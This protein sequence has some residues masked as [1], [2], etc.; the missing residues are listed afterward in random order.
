MPHAPMAIGCVGSTSYDSRTDR[1]LNK[2]EVTAPP[3]EGAYIHGL[4]MEVHEIALHQE[5]FLTQGARW[6]LYAGSIAESKLKDLHPPM[7]VMFI[8][9][10]TQDIGVSVPSSSMLCLFRCACNPS[11]ASMY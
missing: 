2:E 11:L 5:S 6:D 7:P 9:A 1:F 8:K 3:R 4:F 10:V